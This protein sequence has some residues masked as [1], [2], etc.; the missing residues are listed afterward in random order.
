MNIENEELLRKSVRNIPINWLNE[1]DREFEPNDRSSYSEMVVAAHVTSE[2]AKNSLKDWVD[3]ARRAEHSWADIGDLLGISRQAAQQ[4][5]GGGSTEDE[6]KADGFIV[7]KGATAF[8]ELDLLSA[9]GE[10]RLE[11][12]ALAALRLFFRKSETRWEYQRTVLTKPI[13]EGWEYVAGWLP[14]R[15]YKRPVS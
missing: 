4:R 13:G 14:F 10:D 3:G 1:Q 7:L 12:V 2:E 6:H 5:F 8:N 11:L 9:A 15:Y